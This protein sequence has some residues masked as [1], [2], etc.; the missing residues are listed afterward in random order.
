MVLETFVLEQEPTARQRAS[1]LSRRYE[2]LEAL[3]QA[4]LESDQIRGRRGRGA[5]PTMHLADDEDAPN[6]DSSA[7]SPRASSVERQYLFETAATELP[8]HGSTRRPTPK[9]ED[10]TILSFAGEV[11]MEL[12]VKLPFFISV[13]IMMS[14]IDR[15]EPGWQVVKPDEQ[16]RFA[17]EFFDKGKEGKIQKSDFIA[18]MQSLAKDFTSEELEMM[19]EEAKFEDGDL[20][21]MTY[22]EFVK[23][24]MR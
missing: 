24:M 3:T 10:T 8:E 16:H 20:E 2:A 19:F 18:Q 1:S 13:D 22:K 17:F 11:F 5:A 14:A 9:S 12:F 4:S 23:M 21:Q 6:R 15:L 7:Q